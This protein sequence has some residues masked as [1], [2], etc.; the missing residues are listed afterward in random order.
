MTSPPSTV[1]YTRILIFINA[2]FWLAFSVITAVGAHPSYAEA[3]TLRWI[4]ATVA[5]L[6]AGVLGALAV[7]LQRQSPP[8]Y[9]L[10]V[11]SLAAMTVAAVLD[12]LG[13]ADVVFAVMTL[14]PLALLL[15]D[16]NWYQRIVIGSE[17]DKR[18]A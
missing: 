15:K 9:W 8:A 7:L 3:N 10:A 4:M 1:R 6:V 16:R 2:L 13:L 18:V 12:D 17:Q 5:L 11:A 14:L